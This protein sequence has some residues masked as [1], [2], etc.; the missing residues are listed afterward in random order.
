MYDSANEKIQATSQGDQTSSELNASAQS[1]TGVPT[2]EQEHYDVAYPQP[3]STYDL[4]RPTQDKE[5]EEGDYDV[6]V[7]EQQRK[8]PQ[9]LDGND[10]ITDEH[11]YAD[12]SESKPKGKGKVGGVSPTPGD[13]YEDASILMLTT[14]TS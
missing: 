12:I 5:R 1:P 3:V 13:D 7:H 6:T 14:H 10:T 4:L 8:A 11:D 9:S 2:I